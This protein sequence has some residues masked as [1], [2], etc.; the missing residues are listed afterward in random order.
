MSQT[1]QLIDLELDKGAHN[2]HP[3]GVVLT[4][5]K[6]SFLWDVDGRRYIDMMGAKRFAAL[7]EKLEKKYGPR[8]KA[9]K[10]VLDLAAKGETFYGRF[11]P[12]TGRAAA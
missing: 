12:K 4:R 7:C 5:A 10:I 11:A 6:G 9:P 8:F 3:V 1:R 2:Y